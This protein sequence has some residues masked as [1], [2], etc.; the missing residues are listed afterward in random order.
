MRLGVPAW[1]PHGRTPPARACSHDTRTAGS[2]RTGAEERPLGR[3]DARHHH[4]S[5][6]YARRPVPLTRLSPAGPIDDDSGPASRA[7]SPRVLTR[8]PRGNHPCV[9]QHG[10]VHACTRLHCARWQRP[11]ACEGG[12][13]DGRRQRCRVLAALTPPPRGRGAWMT[14]GVRGAE[15]RAARRSCAAGPAHGSHGVHAPA[16]RVC[17]QQRGRHGPA[18]A[19]R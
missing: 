7:P 19:R 11:V 9:P 14:S 1:W 10:G 12:A 18:G 15:Q 2:D 13:T 17:G 6:V 3:C 16:D 4:R 5:S 8:P